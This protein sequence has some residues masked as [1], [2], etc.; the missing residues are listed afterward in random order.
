MKD[1]NN[2]ENDLRKLDDYIE[3]LEYKK[4]TIE[5]NN[6]KKKMLIDEL[7]KINEEE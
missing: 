4:K 5:K 6:L 2:I 3:T 7:K 1:I